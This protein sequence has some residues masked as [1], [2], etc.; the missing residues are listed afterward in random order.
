MQVLSRH[1]MSLRHLFESVCAVVG[2]SKATSVRIGKADGGGGGASANSKPNLRPKNLLSFE[3]FKE[4]NR[5]L[6]LI[7]IDLSERD[8]ALCFA[9]SR[10]VVVDSQSEKGRMRESSLPF[11]G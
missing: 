9:W 10:M 2:D 3:R 6:G 7:D 8:A 11:E 5:R 4:L 1:E